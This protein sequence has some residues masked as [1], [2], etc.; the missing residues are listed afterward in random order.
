MVYDCTDGKITM[1]QNFFPFNSNSDFTELKNISWDT[2]A[3]VNNVNDPSGNKLN[4]QGK[5]NGT[6]VDK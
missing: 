3:S 1:C 4:C 6:Y 2:T 5:T